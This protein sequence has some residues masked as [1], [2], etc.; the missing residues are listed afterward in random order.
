MAPGMAWQI[1]GKNV[2]F[3]IIYTAP[4]S[5][6]I[7]WTIGSFLALFGS[8]FS[9]NVIYDIGTKIILLKKCFFFFFFSGWYFVFLKKVLLTFFR[10]EKFKI[11]YSCVQSF[12]FIRSAKGHQLNIQKHEIL[13]QIWKCACD[14]GFAATN[15]SW[16]FAPGGRSWQ[17]LAAPG[18]YKAHILHDFW[19]G[20]A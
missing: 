1:A 4:F 12:E 11:L 3:F 5:N 14:L 20:R 15:C 16:I 8:R 9:K 10:S 18:S 19:P 17:L 7:W 6:A 13:Q 2:I